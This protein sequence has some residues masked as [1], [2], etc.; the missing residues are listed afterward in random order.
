MLPAL[1]ADGVGGSFILVALSKLAKLTEDFCAD[2]LLI[3]GAP[4][5][6]S[7]EVGGRHGS[8]DEV[9]LICRLGS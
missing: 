4:V 5:S 8:G 3:E 7:I 9:V 2:C 6:N 1:I